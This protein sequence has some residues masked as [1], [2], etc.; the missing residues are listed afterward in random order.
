[1]ES[2]GTRPARSS[3]N[4]QMSYS[5][6]VTSVFPIQ[7]GPTETVRG[8]CGV[9]SV[10][11]PPGTGIISKLKEIM[12]DSRPQS[13]V[14][15]L[16]GRTGADVPVSEPLYAVLARALEL[17]RLSDGAFDPTV[18]PFVEL[19]RAARRTGRLPE[20]AALDSAAARVGWRRVHLG[21]AARTVRLD[22]ADRRI[23]LGGI[24]KGYTLD[25]ARAELR[26]QG[27]TSALLEAGGDISAGDSSPG[28]AGW[29]VG[30]MPGGCAL[31]NAW[32]ATSGDAEEFV[33]RDGVRYSHGVDPRTGPG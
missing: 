6:H 5:S 29:R 33:A 26:R 19:W 14:R 13:E 28:R 23:D 32:G 11:V 12:S 4:A 30:G 8:P 27:V 7:N 25:Q 24:A 21:P 22:V 9:S 20:R 10:T 1:M 31:A 2:V 18:G 15:R 17:A 3:R 16:T